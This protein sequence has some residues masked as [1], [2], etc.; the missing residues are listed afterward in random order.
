VFAKAS[1]AI[2]IAYAYYS[3]FSTRNITR[4]AP[5]HEGYFTLNNAP[6]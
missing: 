3:C 2:V 6:Y 1:I 5:L 4:P